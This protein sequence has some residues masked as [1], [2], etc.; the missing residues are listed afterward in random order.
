SRESPCSSDCHR[1]IAPACS[2]H[3]R[4]QRSIAHDFSV[5]SLPGRNLARKYGAAGPN[6]IG[7]ERTRRSE[8]ESLSVFHQSA[9]PPADGYNRGAISA[10]ASGP[11]S[12]KSGDEPGLGQARKA[13]RNDCLQH[14]EVHRRTTGLV[15]FVIACVT[16]IRLARRISLPVCPLTSV[17]CMPRRS[18]GEGGISVNNVTIY[19]SR[20]S[21]WPA[22]VL[23]K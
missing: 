5:G 15:W 23:T 9:I 12:R 16:S 11:D 13:D 17:L 7:F 19:L 1:R 8:I 4:G 6:P 20:R 22:K 10:N 21:P 3:G 14:R 2:T 18:L